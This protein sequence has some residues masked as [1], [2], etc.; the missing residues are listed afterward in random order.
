MYRC[1]PVA[2][3][4]SSTAFEVAVAG[5]LT[6]SSQVLRILAHYLTRIGR[7]L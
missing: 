2:E 6:G 1:T 4:W 3:V 5:E 7:L